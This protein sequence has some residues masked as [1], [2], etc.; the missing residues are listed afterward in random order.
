[1]NTFTDNSKALAEIKEKWTRDNINW[2]HC[3]VTLCAAL[4][5]VESRCVLK[6]VQLCRFMANIGLGVTG[7]VQLWLGELWELWELWFELW[8]SYV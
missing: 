6:C 5:I 8:L 3:G 7:I 4:G 1:M 2:Q